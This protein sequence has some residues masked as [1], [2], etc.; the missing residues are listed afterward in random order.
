VRGREDGQ[1]DAGR[2]RGIMAGGSYYYYWA[3]GRRFFDVAKALQAFHKDAWVDED[4][5]VRWKSNN[6]I[7]FDDVTGDWA[8]L[9]LDF[10]FERS[11]RVRKEEAIVAIEEYCRNYKGPSE[12]E[13]FEMRAAFG[14][15]ATV[16]NVITGKETKL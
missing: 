8:K 2:K 16:V 9:H 4:R 6:R 14:E 10:D 12:E 3:K 13:L 1:Q 11:E 7:P 5:V 15:G